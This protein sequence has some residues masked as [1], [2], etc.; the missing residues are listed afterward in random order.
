MPIHEYECRKCHHRFETLVRS[1]D[2]PQCPQCDSRA[3][4]RL[5]SAF[6]LGKAEPARAEAPASCGSCGMAPGSCMLQ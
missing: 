5:L 6:A 3:L 2:R 1:S 4:E